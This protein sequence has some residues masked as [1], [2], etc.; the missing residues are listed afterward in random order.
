MSD[1]TAA[2]QSGGIFV[3]VAGLAVFAIASGYLMSLIPLTL[4]YFEL[5]ASLASWLASTFYLGLLIGALLIERV[6]AKIGHRLS[7]IGF[8]FLLALTIM[9]MPV[10]PE[11]WVWLLARFIAGIAVAGIFVVVE[12]WLLI[13]D[14]KKERAKRLGFYMTALYGGGT[15]G[16]FGI[17]FIGVEGLLPFFSILALVVLAM[18]PALV[19]KHSQPA[20]EQHTSLTSKQILALSKPAILGCLVSGIVMSTIYGLLPFSLK[21]QGLTA[22]Q[23]SGLMASTVLGGMAIQPVVSALSCKM[24]KTLL[25]AAACLLGIFAIGMM[26]LFEGYAVMVIGLALLGMSSFALYP[27]AISL[28]CDALNSTQIV[29]ATQVMLFSYSI[30]SVAGPLGAGSFLHHANGLMNFFFISLASTAVYMLMVSL[31]QKPQVVAG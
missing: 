10:M 25:M 15:L 22:E 29:S 7:F 12:S 16:Q 17:G 26:T 24:S 8:Q 2:R 19:S 4:S 21:L 27:I 1:I 20:C 28:A 31:K 5:P 13:G 6:V 30:G 9:I 18:V 14:N 23:I 11:Q 3:P